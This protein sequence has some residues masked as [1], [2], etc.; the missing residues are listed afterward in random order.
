VELAGI[1][2]EVVA[3]VERDTTALLRE[4]IRIDTSNPPGN[5][6]RVA[7]FLDAYFRRFGLQGEIVGEPAERRSFVLRLAGSRPGPRLAL[8]AH[9]DVVP[10]EAASWT[11]PPFEAVHRDGYIWGRGAIDVKNLLAAFAVA[12]R[13]LH[14]DGRPFAGEIVYIAAAD[15]EDGAVGGARWLC[16]ERPDLVRCDCLLNEGGGEFLELAGG[17]RLYELHV[18]EKGTAQF[19]VTVRGEAGHASVPM[20]R[21]NAVVG[22][23]DVIRA[24]H[25]REP[26]LSLDTVPPAYVELLVDDPALR[27]RLLD[28][29]AARGALAEL[30][31]RDRRAADLLAPL[32][33]ITF[34]PTIVHS[35]GDAVNVFPQQTVVTVDCRMPVGWTEERVLTE[36]HDALAGVDATFDIEFIGTVSGNASPGETRFAEAIATVMG[37]LV[38]DSAVVPI[39]SVGFTDSN[40]FRAA[41]PEVVAY[42]FAPFVVDSS[43]KVTPLFHNV[44]ERIAVGDLTFQSL[45]AYELARELLA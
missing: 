40:W 2:P 11:E 10:A 26:R 21:G 8:M 44:D 22:A 19:R 29:G 6:S 3:R 42:N 43:E 23:A 32:Y 35:S 16:K 25:D 30:G 14:E 13:R 17:R 45:F 31:E 12:L 39:H 1:A 15:E 18:G 33:G 37:R 20:R 9:E 7:E 28:E 34:S 27:E 38:P 5:E 36:I 41:F 24:L 4:L